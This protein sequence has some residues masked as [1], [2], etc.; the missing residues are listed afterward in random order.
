MT[1]TK[2]FEYIGADGKV[3]KVFSN[4]TVKNAEGNI[5]EIEDYAMPGFIIYT[6]LDKIIFLDE[7]YKAKLKYNFLEVIRCGNTQFTTLYAYAIIANRKI[8]KRFLFPEEVDLLNKLAHLSAMDFWFMLV[9]RDGEFIVRDIEKGR[10][11]ILSKG[12]IELANGLNGCSN[13]N[14]SSF[15]KATLFSVLYRMGVELRLIS[16]IL[17]N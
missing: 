17:G 11:M 6:G 12:I 14:L 4:G 3:R 1:A 5:V 2:V 16:W 7:A 8:S 13:Y 9:N 10:D 15:E